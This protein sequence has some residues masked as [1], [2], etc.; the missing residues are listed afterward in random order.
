MR[1]LPGIVRDVSTPKAL[2]EV[3]PAAELMS[4]IFRLKRKMRHA[5]DVAGAFQRL[6]ANLVQCLVEREIQ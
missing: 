5:E 1:I 4:G 6:P 3:T 2:T